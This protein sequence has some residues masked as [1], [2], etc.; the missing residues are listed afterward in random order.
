MSNNLRVQ[1][2]W[3]K[4]Q[5]TKPQKIKNHVHSINLWIKQYSCVSYKYGS[6]LK[7]I[8]KYSWSHATV[9]LHSTNSGINLHIDEASACQKNKPK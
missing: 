4:G 9:H 2:V 1:P 7:D 8:Y 3:A 5:V 6:R